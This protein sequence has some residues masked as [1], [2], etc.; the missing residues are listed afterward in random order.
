MILA[1]LCYV[2]EF[3]KWS[4][5]LSVD[6]CPTIWLLGAG[7]T[8][9]VEDAECPCHFI[10]INIPTVRFEIMWCLLADAQAQADRLDAEE[11]AGTEPQSGDGDMP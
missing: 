1:L 8:P 5:C 6:I 9:P 4:L 3:T 11:R 10:T 7:Y 2:L